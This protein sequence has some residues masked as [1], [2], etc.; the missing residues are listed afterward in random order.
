MFGYSFMNY[1]CLLRRLAEGASTRDFLCCYLSAGVFCVCRVNSLVC[2]YYGEP[3]VCAYYGEPL[4][5]L[6]FTRRWTLLGY[7]YE[8][9]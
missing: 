8:Q 2:A 6:G 5:F 9:D 4:V 3:L 1:N 7:E